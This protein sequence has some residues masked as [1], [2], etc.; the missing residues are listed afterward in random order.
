MLHCPSPWS[1]E[2]PSA[3]RGQAGQSGLDIPHIAAPGEKL[4][5]ASHQPQPFP[6]LSLAPAEIWPAVPSTDGQTLEK[7]RNR[8]DCF[9]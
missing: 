7:Y 9:P 1:R 2:L 3:A 5:S 6:T 4:G 8:H